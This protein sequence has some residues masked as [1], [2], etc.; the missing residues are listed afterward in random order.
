MNC[1]HVALAPVMH[2]AHHALAVWGRLSFA[3]AGVL[4]LD[5]MCK[6]H[7]LTP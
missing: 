1:V 2:H 5:V 4:F 7:V 3:W 6:L